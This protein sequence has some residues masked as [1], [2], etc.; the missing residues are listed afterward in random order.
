MT[1]F[2][3]IASGLWL[4]LIL[5]ILNIT[6]ASSLVALQNTASNFFVRCDTGE[7]S[8]II[9]PFLSYVFNPYNLTSNF[10][11]LWAIVT[12]ILGI[13]FFFQLIKTYDQWKYKSILLGTILVIALISSLGAFQAGA[14]PCV[15]AALIAGLKGRGNEPNWD[16]FIVASILFDLTLG[17]A[18]FLTQ[19]A[20]YLLAFDSKRMRLYII[21][22]VK[23]VLIGCLII[24]FYM[25]MIDYNFI[26]INTSLKTEFIGPNILGVSLKLISLY[27]SS[28]LA[29]VFINAK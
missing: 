24:T 11:S 26:Q 29:L 12:L 8:S 10:L 23:S 16:F 2:L 15:L 19:A 18:I 9:L 6:S 17:T 27:L 22:I 5:F 1:P 13:Y 4:L 21:K 3:G 28:L 7:C 20:L 14:L 25:S